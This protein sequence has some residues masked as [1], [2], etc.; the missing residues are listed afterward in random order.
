MSPHTFPY[1]A[2]IT[3]VQRN[4]KQQYSL[5]TKLNRCNIIFSHKAPSGLIFY[6]PEKVLNY[7]DTV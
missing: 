2:M 4:R 5:V 6:F 7:M 1:K 3:A